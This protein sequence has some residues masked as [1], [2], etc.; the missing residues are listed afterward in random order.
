M[1]RLAMKVIVLYCAVV[2]LLALGV[3]MIGVN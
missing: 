1:I 3:M 2:F